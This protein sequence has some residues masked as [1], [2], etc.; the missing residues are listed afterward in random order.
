MKSDEG[1]KMLSQN[2]P[3]VLET[4]RLLLRGHS[5]SDFRSSADMWAD[6]NVVAFISGIPS[7]EEQS[8]T[9]LLRYA[10]HWH[11]LGFGYWVVTRK[12][13]NAFLGEV[14]FANYKRDTYP[15]FEMIPEA[16]W[17]FATAAHGQGYATEAVGA[18]LSWADQ[19]L[20]SPTTVAM[21][22]PAHAAS[23]NVARKLGYGR[24]ILGRYGDE[25]VLFL[26]RSRQEQATE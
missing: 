3:P 23:I 14:G 4:E 20:A 11:L 19:N 24:D 12:K 7:S 21:F 15:T 13:D 2:S 9:R 10:G 16:G 6:D 26:E 1:S 5:L 17:V 22:D 18:V 25:E 8:W